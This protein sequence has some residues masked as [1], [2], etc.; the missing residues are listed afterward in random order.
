MHLEKAGWCDGRR[1]NATD[2]VYRAG[3]AS[4]GGRGRRCSAF[5]FRV[6]RR[7]ERM[8][9]RRKAAPLPTARGTVAPRRRGGPWL[10]WPWCSTSRSCSTCGSGQALRR[11]HLRTADHPAGDEGP[12]V[13]GD[14]H[15]ELFDI[16]RPV[17]TSGPRD[18]I[19]DHDR[20]VADPQ[21]RWP[22]A[23]PASCARG[24]RP[25]RATTRSTPPTNP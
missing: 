24:G 13:H 21:P 22:I 14:D 3:G 10:L 12:R 7:G 23:T 16:H 5:H 15:L 17:K 8:Q 9:P 11:K 18:F 1:S 2:R 4:A 25:S 19:G 20:A 6:A